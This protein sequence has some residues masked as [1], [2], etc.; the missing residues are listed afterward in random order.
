VVSIVAVVPKLKHAISGDRQPEPSTSHALSAAAAKTGNPEGIPV[1]AD[2][3][4][5]IYPNNSDGLTRSESW[6][7][8]IKGYIFHLKSFLED[9]CCFL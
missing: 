3:D 4:D 2:A 9:H 8:L 1:F 7:W 5:D 6:L